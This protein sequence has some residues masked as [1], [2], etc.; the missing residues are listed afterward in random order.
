[1]DDLQELELVHKLLQGVSPSLTD[2]L[3]VFCLLDLNVKGLKGGEEMFVCLADHRLNQSVYYTWLRVACDNSI[4]NQVLHDL[5][6]TLLN[7]LLASFDVELWVLW[8]LIWV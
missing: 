5:A 4:V 7:C 8:G 6:H 1:M 2:G 3:D